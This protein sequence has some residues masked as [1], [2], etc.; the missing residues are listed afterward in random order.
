MQM[1]FFGRQT[2]TW[3]RR[4][5]LM[6]ALALTAGLLTA[7]PAR[8]QS[9]LPEPGTFDVT[10]FLGL[11]FGIGDGGDNFDRDGGMLALGGAFSYNWTSTIAFE[12]EL[13]ILP[14]II[15]DDDLIDVRV[16]TVSGNVLYHFDTQTA[17]VPYATVGL[18]FGRTSFDFDGDDEATTELAVNFG[19]GVKYEV[20]RNVQVRG[21]L[22]Y[23][24]INDENPDFWRLYGGV[25]FRFPR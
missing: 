14:D 17:F 19:G 6:G 3:S 11:N 8:A 1:S 16:T 18:G 24:N 13:G 20:A 23:F 15:G 7:A 9:P 25:A 21:D 5:G 2:G 12:G 10:P 4:A 22:R